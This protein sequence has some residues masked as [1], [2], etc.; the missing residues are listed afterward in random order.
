MVHVVHVPEPAIGG[1]IAVD[2]EPLAAAS[3]LVAGHLRE[4]ADRNVA[5]EG[6]L[7]LHAGDHGA[8]G[9]LIAE[10]ARQAGA[11]TI[12][13]GAP[14]HGGLATLMDASTS[15]ALL[16]ATS[17]HVLIVNPDAPAAPPPA[18]ENTPE[19]SLR[20]RSSSRSEA[21]VT[22]ARTVLRA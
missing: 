22:R 7:L 3:A 6:Q 21:P 16:R 10:Y 20:N 11:S 4:L 19:Q 12:V 9:R 14:R 1:D 18:A 15:Q 5:A 17:T 13:I 8:A 2:G